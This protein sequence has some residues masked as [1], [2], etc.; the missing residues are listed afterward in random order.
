MHLIWMWPIIVAVVFTL[1]ACVNVLTGRVAKDQRLVQL[2]YLPLLWFGC[3]HF[4][5]TNPLLP[6]LTLVAGLP[7]LW[8]IYKGHLRMRRAKK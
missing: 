2:A 8:I 6:L 4:V 5:T 1:W 3:L 7:C